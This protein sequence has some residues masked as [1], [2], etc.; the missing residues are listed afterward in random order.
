MSRTSDSRV[1]A[2]QRPPLA[3]NRLKLTA[4][5]SFK[6]VGEPSTVMWRMAIRCLSSLAA[7]N[8]SPPFWPLPAT[9]V[10]R[11]F[12]NE[13]N[14]RSISSTTALPAFS[15]R[16]MAGMFRSSIAARSRARISAAVTNS[17]RSGVPSFRGRLAPARRRSLGR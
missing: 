1:I 15:I 11:F 16:R 8:P 9:T 6:A 3:V 7:T 2:W 10:T 12:R 4:A 13:P 17:I 14:C 5:A